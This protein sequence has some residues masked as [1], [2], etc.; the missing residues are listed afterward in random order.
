MRRI[1]E[2]DPFRYRQPEI[3]FIRDLSAP[4]HTGK[5]PRWNQSPAGEDETDFSAADFR[6]EYQDELLE[7]AYADF[8]TFLEIS[9]VQAREGG[10]VIRVVQGETECFEAYEIIVDEDGCTVVSA[11]TEGV[12]R[13]LVFIEDEMLRREGTYLKAGRIQRRPFIKARISRCYFTPAS[14]AGNEETEN[15]LLDDIDYYPDEYLNRMAHDGINALWLGA[16]LRYLVKNPRIPEYGANSERLLKK[17]ASVV[18]KCR[19][20]G[21]K[22]YLFAVDPAS[23]YNN[24]H[25]L[26][27]PDLIGDDGYEGGWKMLCPSTE[28]GAAYMK[29]AIQTV[30]RSVP[31]L[32]G[33]INLSTGESLSHCGSKNVLT[34]RRCRAKFGTLGKT[35]AAAE[36]IFADA[37]REVAPQAEYI[38]WTYD[39]RVWQLSDIEDACMSRDLNVRHLVNFEDLGKPV[40]LGKKRLALD[41]WLSYAGPGELFEH[42]IGFNKE[43]GVGTW[44]KIQVCSSHE[45]STVPYVPA[46]GL[47]YEKYKYMYENG[48]GGVMQ[49]WFFGNYP[50]LMNKAAGELAFLP[51]FDDKQAFLEH[52]AGVYWGKDAPAAARAWNLFT[53][54]YKNFPVGVMYE[55]YGPMQ[56]SPC[57]PYHLK[58][59]DRTMASTW[60]LNDLA[61]GDRIGDCILNT[62]T[63]EE[64]IALTEEMVS[65]WQRGWAEFGAIP[66][67][68]DPHRTEQKHVAS[69]VGLIFESGL[70]TLRFYALRRLL[71]IG[72]GDAMQLLDQMQAI[73]EREMEVSAQLIPIARADNRI[74]YHS[75]AIG[76]KIFPEKLEWRIGEMQKLLDTEFAEVRRRIESGLVPLEFYY[77]SEEGARTYQIK[78]EEIDRAGWL[79]FMD[80]D[81]NESVRT[82]VRFSSKDGRHTMEFRLLGPGDKL[83]I[84]PEFR[85]FHLTAPIRLKD[86][87]LSLAVTETDSFGLF[88]DRLTEWRNHFSLDYRRE[89]D[90]EY[91]AVSYRP[92]EVNAE[93]YEPFRITADRHGAHE[94]FIAP[95]TGAVQKIGV[96]NLA[97]EKALFVIPP[98]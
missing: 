73:V 31:G 97:P 71:G 13:A 89:G 88:G 35:L 68:S 56:D 77:G 84:R 20:Y 61:G 42:C 41:Y 53:E 10:R 26:N 75:E 21:I 94:E 70:D 9:G 57:A 58:P 44:A 83:V 50:C 46:P 3:T 59:V 15:E 2:E 23:S 78:A 11:D 8:R 34:C 27:H 49:C 19:R 38:S 80:G 65:L 98:V 69:A 92:D 39:Q 64:L 74:G 12:R 67:F 91:Y 6:P 52:L 17:L 87:G 14:H 22:I 86:G 63:H 45:I 47:L 43:R 30:F 76:F 5:P 81:G 82:F 72:K 16:T 96:S 62:H 60:L 79:P 66:D 33:F 36:K 55:W 29:E 95:F 93:A 7:T 28:G 90:A 37:I 4:V 32:A 54:G 18:E 40:Q 51:F 25:L 24:P 1:I 85:M 48:V